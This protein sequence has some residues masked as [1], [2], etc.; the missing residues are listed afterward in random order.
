MPAPALVQ[1]LPPEPTASPE[2]TPAPTSATTSLTVTRRKAFN[3]TIT[4]NPDLV[5]FDYNHLLPSGR[6]LAFYQTIKNTLPTD[7]C[8]II[9]VAS[10]YNHEGCNLIAFETALIAATQ[11]GLRVLFI[12]TTTDPDPIRLQLSSKL[13]TTLDVLLQAGGQLESAVVGVENTQF[14]YTLLRNQRFKDSAIANLDNFRELLTLMRGMYDLIIIPSPAI[15]TDVLCASLS[16][17]AD[18]AIVVVQAERTRAPVLAQVKDTV[19]QNGGKVIGAIM[20]KR[21]YYIP[22]WIYRFI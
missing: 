6:L 17:L 20:N 5:K 21:R 4:N 2:P 14:Y 9:Q 3:I 13:D 18:A 15:L 12:D 10:A 11:I 1:P 7:T 22:R 19:Q 8:Q 16:R